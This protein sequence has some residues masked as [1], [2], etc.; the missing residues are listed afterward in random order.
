MVNIL[1]EFLKTKIEILDLS[2][3]IE[4]MKGVAES[5]EYKEMTDLVV[6]VQE[7]IKK[8]RNHNQ[9]EMIKLDEVLKHLFEL[10]D[11]SNMAE[12]SEELRKILTEARR[13]NEEA[14]RIARRYSGSYAFVKTYTDAV[15]IHPEIDRET[16]ARVIDVVFEAVQEIKSAN[17]LILQGRDNFI[18]NLNRKTTVKLIKSGLYDDAE[19]DDWYD[20]LLSETYANMKIF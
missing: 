8:N 11:I 16:I 17:M 7:E 4:A 2:K 5:E 6:Q 15:E 12:I 13:I 18:A 1:Y 9:I 14:E 19:L 10:L 3:L 20:D